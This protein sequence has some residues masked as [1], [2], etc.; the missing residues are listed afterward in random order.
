[1]SVKQFP[2]EKREKGYPFFPHL[3]I[4]PSDD[5]DNGNES[6][7]EA[8]QSVMARIMAA[9]FVSGGKKK[10]SEL[11]PYELMCE[12][13]DVLLKQSKASKMDALQKLFN[14]NMKKKAYPKRLIYFN[15]KQ[16]THY[17]GLKQEKEGDEIM[18]YD[19]YQ[20]VQAEDTE[21]YCQLFA[22]FLLTDP[23]GFHF[24]REQT[25]IDVEEFEKLCF[26]TQLCLTKCLNLLEKNPDI[27]EKFKEDFEKLDFEYYGI[28]EGTT[29]DQYLADF[30][31][32]NRDEKAVK[33]YI[34]D[35][36]L[37]GWSQGVVKGLLWNHIHGLKPKSR[38]TVQ[39]K[40]EKS[41]STAGRRTRRRK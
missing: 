16:G 37:A 3:C 32:L 34:Y 5:I 9:T 11:S 10:T 15:P 38:K 26:N 35:Q 28:T 14:D 21:G 24:L 12:K 7:Y 6:Q 31:F 29:C 4:L 36:P 25:F 27:K 13:Y 30:D 1:M 23:N 18:R 19:P 33:Y 20:Y 17:I 8:F 22:F 2:T 41:K 39:S 40:K